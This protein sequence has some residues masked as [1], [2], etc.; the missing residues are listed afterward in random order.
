MTTFIILAAGKG[1]R[2]KS[3]LPKVLHPVAGRPMIERILKTIR[4][5]DQTAEVRIVLGHG[6]QLVQSVVE[7]FGASVFI[8][9]KQLGTADAVK[10][11]QVNN[12]SGNV[13][14]LNGDHPL[15]TSEDIKGFIQTFQELKVDLGV[16]SCLLKN[17]GEFGRIVRQKGEIKAIVEAK[18]AS[19]D[20]L[21]INE[22]NT[23]IYVI[24]G[25]LLSAILPKIN[26]KN[27][28]GEYYLTDLLALAL[29]QKRKV[30]TI[31]T[32]PRVALGVNCQSDLARATKVAFK[33]N[34]DYH[35][36]NGVVVIDPKTTYIEDSVKIGSGSV[37][38][39]NNF[40]RGET[41]IGSFCVVESNC[42]LSDSV[43]GDSI[44]VKSGCY[45]ERTEI[46]S[47]ASVGPYARLRPDTV[48]GQD[49]H[50]GNFVE[51]KKVRFGK[52]SKAGHLTYLGDAEIGEDVNIG[53]GT[54]T[55]NYAVDRKKYVTKIGN[56]V[57]VGSDS[58]FVAPVTVGD[59]AVIGSGSTIT[60][61]VPAKAL[62][63]A[64]AKQVTKENYVSSTPAISGGK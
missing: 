46:Q 2:M 47:K 63:V 64:R 12:I 59:D 37:I 33:K 3:P 52:G 8:Q 55:C 45:I 60:K 15:I 35:M 30:A 42:F 18:D 38:Y 16:V 6:I 44:Q 26:N 61:D 50:V 23:G 4:A 14:I 13:V 39:P 22:I 36:E 62:G 25:E 57:F 10:A 51:M 54:I 49:A 29:E 58:Q 7:P 19:S 34:V 17:P 53:C 41:Q 32:N 21:K 28:K 27:S 1:T 48:I 5:V 20:T 31:Q 11:A 43:L 40:I 9:D 24:N 56:R